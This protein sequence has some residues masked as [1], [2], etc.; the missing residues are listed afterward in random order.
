MCYDGTCSFLKTL[1]IVES[2]AKNKVCGKNGLG[3]TVKNLK[4]LHNLSSNKIRN[5]Q[6]AQNGQKQSY[7]RTKGKYSFLKYTLL[8]EGL[9]KALAKVSMQS[10]VTGCESWVYHFGEKA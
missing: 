7:T 4:L 6:A 3:Q 1:Y 8:R 10:G 5:W 9:V 2:C